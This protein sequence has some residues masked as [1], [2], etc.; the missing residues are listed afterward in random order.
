LKKYAAFLQIEIKTSRILAAFIVITHALAM[1]ASIYNGLS[2][3]VQ[4]AL[5]LSLSLHLWLMLQRH[6]LNA[7][8]Y[9][10]K[11]TTAG[12]W[13]L[14]DFTDFRAI[15]ILPSTVIARIAI[16]LHYKALE[17]GKGSIII[18]RDAVNTE[19][20]RKLT[21]ALKISGLD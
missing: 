20:F 19:A 4:T 6:V 12:G 15:Q 16:I 1:L 18:L 21:V 10:L 7:P 5:V 9:T 11:Y 14:A 8:P 2:G 17:G 13:A 3:A